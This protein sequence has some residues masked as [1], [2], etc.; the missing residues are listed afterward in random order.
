VENTHCELARLLYDHALRLRCKMRLTPQ[1]GAFV[2]GG[3]GRCQ[4]VCCQLEAAVYNSC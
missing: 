3:K 1:L 4:P 2:L